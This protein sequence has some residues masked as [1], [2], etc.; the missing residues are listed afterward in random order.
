MRRMRTLAEGGLQAHW[1]VKARSGC[2]RRRQ[3]ATIVETAIVLP[4]IILLIIGTLD[5]GIGVYGYNTLAEAVRVGSRYAIVHGSQSKSPVGPA[6]NDA[7]IESVVRAS[8]PGVLSSRMT[9]TSS[10]PNGDNAPGNLVTVTTS[11]RFN[12]ILFW[13]FTS[14]G[15]TL[16]STS[17]MV[18]CH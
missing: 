18:I 4:V 15:L 12:P 11:Y 17:T 14:R 16:S 13:V 10:W 3:G 8:T 7:T 1:W 6:S 5:L 2:T 9:V